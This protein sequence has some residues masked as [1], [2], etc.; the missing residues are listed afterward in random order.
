[1]A[2]QIVLI[3]SKLKQ[4]ADAV[5]VEMLRPGPTRYGS[6]KPN[7]RGSW[8]TVLV[9]GVPVAVVWTDWKDGF[10]VIHLRDAEVTDLLGNYV[11]T[12]KALDIPA[13][14]AYSSLETVVSKF[15]TEQNVS[16]SAQTDGKL[17]N[18]MRNE[19]TEVDTRGEQDGTR[20]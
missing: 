1:M 17:G 14:W 19:E 15:D 12:A 8:K 16:L 3:D 20:Q 6:L 5:P 9:E 13:G 2:I 7:T 4:L 10:D 18:I 11:I